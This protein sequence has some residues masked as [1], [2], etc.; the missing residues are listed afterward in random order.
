[1]SNRQACNTL[2]AWLKANL[3]TKSLAPLTGTDR[4]ALFAFIQIVDLYAHDHDCSVIPAMK[5]VVGRMQQTTWHLAY[6]SIAHIMDWPDRE[7]IWC[8]KMELPKPAGAGRCK[9]ES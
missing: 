9:H 4:R 2:P 3:G 6:H 8:Q 5:A 7:F 1:M